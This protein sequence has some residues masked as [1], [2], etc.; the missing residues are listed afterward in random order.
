MFFTSKGSVVLERVR[1]ERFALN[2][3]VKCGWEED[4]LCPFLA[5]KLDESQSVGS[6]C[7]KRFN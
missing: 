4:R 5:D 2:I 3:F 6:I 1:F 7:A